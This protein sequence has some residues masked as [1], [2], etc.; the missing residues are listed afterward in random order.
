MLWDMSSK[1]GGCPQFDISVSAV[2]PD[3]KKT[4]LWNS[5][6]TSLGGGG[7]G[8]RDGFVKTAGGSSICLIP[9]NLKMVCI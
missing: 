8:G 7:G 3:D 1:Q 6:V 4:G 2:L 5:C 9:S